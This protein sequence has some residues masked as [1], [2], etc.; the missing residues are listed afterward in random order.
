MCNESLTMIKTEAMQLQAA[1]VFFSSDIVPS[2]TTH[3]IP[4][5]VSLISSHNRPQV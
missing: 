2:L 3:L 1:F 5:P 4:R